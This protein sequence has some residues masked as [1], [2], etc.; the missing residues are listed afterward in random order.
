MSVRRFLATRLEP[1]TKY[2]ISYFVKCDGIDPLCTEYNNGGVS[3]YIRQKR[4]D[5]KGGRTWQF[6]E[7]D[8]FLSGTTDWIPQV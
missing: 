6:P 8:N 4:S 1:S 7:H 5:D 2:R 3:V